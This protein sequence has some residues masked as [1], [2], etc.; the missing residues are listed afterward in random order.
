M[1]Y[2]AR[3]HMCKCQKT[4]TLLVAV[5]LTHLTNVPAFCT[6]SDIILSSACLGA[7]GKTHVRVYL[8]NF[9]SDFTAR[10]RTARYFSENGTLRL[11]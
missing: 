1:P 5:H 6:P 9:Y 7:Q 4:P 11:E 2:S 10:Q 8:E 3:V